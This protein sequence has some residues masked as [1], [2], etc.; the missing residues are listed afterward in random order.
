MEAIHVDFTGAFLLLASTVFEIF[1]M[2]EPGAEK[3]I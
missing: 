2:G 3:F 1:S